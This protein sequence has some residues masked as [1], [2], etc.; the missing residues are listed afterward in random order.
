MGQRTD[1]LTALGAFLAD[2]DY[3]GAA[4]SKIGKAMAF[5]EQVLADG[6][7]DMQEVRRKAR[8]QKQSWRTVERAKTDLGIR[9]KRA[10][11]VGASGK[12]EWSLPEDKGDPDDALLFGSGIVHSNIGQ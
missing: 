2:A 6:P 9:S 1:G 5:L 3:S 4:D 12:W 7:L 11:G 8:K 10:G